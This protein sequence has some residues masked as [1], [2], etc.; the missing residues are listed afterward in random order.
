MLL[1]IAGLCSRRPDTK[2]GRRIEREL[3][4]HGFIDGKV[5][6]IILIFLFDKIK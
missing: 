6:G 5:E 2:M 1:Q 3:E 4:E